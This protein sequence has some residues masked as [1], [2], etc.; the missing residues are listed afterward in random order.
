MNIS[1]GMRASSAI[2]SFVIDG[3]ECSF[4][5]IGGGQDR[6]AAGICGSG[7]LDMAGE[8]ARTGLVGKNGAPASQSPRK[9]M[10]LF[11]ISRLI[12]A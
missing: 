9:A 4:E 7:L 6:T 10:D 2:E 3:G 12:P 8:L 5:V 11:N 1:C